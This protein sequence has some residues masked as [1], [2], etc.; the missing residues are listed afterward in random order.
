MDQL[1]A[2][3]A[4]LQ[5]ELQHLAATLRAALAA[6][7]DGASGAA[8]ASLG[9]SVDIAGAGV[10]HLD[11]FLPAHDHTHLQLGHGHDSCH[12]TRSITASMLSSVDTPP[13]AL[14][15]AVD[16]SNGQGPNGAP[17]V[18]IAGLGVAPVYHQP[19]AVSRATLSCSMQHPGS[20]CCTK[21]S[22]TVD[23]SGAACTISLHTTAR[24]A[25]AGRC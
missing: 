8:A 25:W 18:P 23:P 6:A 5:A 10:Q 13:A 3:N 7:P 12:E 21:L 9:G 19:T 22:S 17:G 1:Q 11:G 2:D 24:C 20:I 14:E 16:D 4:E 15:H